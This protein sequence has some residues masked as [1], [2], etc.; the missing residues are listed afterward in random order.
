MTPAP[1]IAVGYVRVSTLGQAT[2]G[3]SLEAQRARIESW[4][5]GNGRS[6]LGV[7]VDAGLSGG[8]ADNRPELQKALDATCERPRPGKGGKGKRKAEDAV[9]RVLVVYSLS[10]LARSVRDTIQIA[11]R[12]DKAGVDL[13]SLSEKIDTSSAAGRMVFRML[14]VLAE[15]E[16]DLISER[17]SASMQHMR[18]QHKRVGGVPY[19]WKL[20]ADGVSLREVVF[21]Q[22]IIG[23]ITGW[24]QEGLTLRAIAARLM[25]QRVPA[26]QGRRWHPKPINDILRRHAADHA[27]QRHAAERA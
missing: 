18:S 10:R 25:E 2:E 7:F 8:R 22:I 21:E 12:L 9:P 20:E 24:R 17:T 4:C 13:V 15:F 27:A 6:L 11:E 19:G 26:K 5:A 3:V 14:A 1:A 16:R 23:Q